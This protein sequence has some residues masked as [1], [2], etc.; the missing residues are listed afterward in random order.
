MKSGTTTIDEFIRTYPANTQKILSKVRKTIHDTVPEA[1]EKISYG[2]PT[3]TLNDKN[4][5][6]FSAYEKHI[7]FYPG[8]N[9]I[10][11]FAK[12]LES[13]NTSKGTVQFALNKPIPYDLIKTITQYCVAQR[14]Q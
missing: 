12:E 5:V 14:L 4:L 11:I 10:E 9:A 3:F 8:S 6:H 1:K 2:I 13:Y 7:G